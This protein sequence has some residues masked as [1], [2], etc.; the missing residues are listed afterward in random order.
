LRIKLES[1]LLVINIF[2]IILILVI[3]LFPTSAVRIVLGIPFVLFF[4]GYVLM[5]ALYP[6]KTG[7]DGITLVAL[8][9]DLS[10][11]VVILIGLILNYTP[12]GIRLESVLYSTF[13]FILTMS[14]IGWLRLRNLLPSERRDISF[15]LSRPSL[16]KCQIEK[17]LSIIL[18]LVVVG[19]FGM[20]VYAIAA[21]KVGQQF[22]EFYILGP[23]GKA[24]SYPQEIQLGEPGKVLVGV[25]N[26]EYETVTY[27]IEVTIDGNKNLEIDGIT[28]PQ[29]GKWED[30]VSFTP[31]IAGDSL[32]VE[33]ILYKNAET[34]PAFDPLRLWV[35]VTA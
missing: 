6:R 35:K 8:S 10:L 7:L 1:G 27:R 30:I 13:A 14:L 3:S 23:D 11:V 9:L 24:D 5:I 16:G 12:F 20:A 18:I 22:T 2:A 29:D 17:T 15:I 33:F 21:P 19:A 28:L 34:T 32:K 25:V 26:H 4:P 31:Q